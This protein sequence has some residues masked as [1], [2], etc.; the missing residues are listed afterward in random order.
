M[1]FVYFFSK[2]YISSVCNVP[3]LHHPLTPES[4]DLGGP[5]AVALA[6][7]VGHQVAGVDQ[8]VKGAA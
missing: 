5:D 4:F 8:V 1:Q 6:E 3:L 7:L 2:F